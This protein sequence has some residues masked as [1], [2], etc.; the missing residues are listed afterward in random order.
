MKNLLV[1]YDEDFVGK[2]KDITLWICRSMH[3]ASIIIMNVIFDLTK[4]EKLIIVSYWILAGKNVYSQ[5]NLHLVNPLLP[6]QRCNHDKNISG[7]L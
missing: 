7:K 4:H 6:H 3:S 2:H 5:S 1:S